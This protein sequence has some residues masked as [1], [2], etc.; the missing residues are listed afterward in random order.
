ME[1]KPMQKIPRLS[2]DII[3]SEKIDGTN[4]SIYIGF[5]GEFKV[6][7]RNRWITPDNDNFGFATWAYKRKDELMQLGIGHHFGEWWGVG[8]NRHYDLSERRFSLFNT[9]RWR[10]FKPACCDLV[11]VLYLGKFDQVIIEDCLNKLKQEGSVAAPGFMN[12]EGV[13]IYHIAG[14][15]LFKKTIE[16]DEKGK[17]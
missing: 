7:S 2:R 16:N 8:I 17:G 12:P 9:L 15:Y 6:G 14:N 13:I 11:P 3:I 5:D 4:A 10:E 1:F